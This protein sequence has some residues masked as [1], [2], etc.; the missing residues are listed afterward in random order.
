MV[1]AEALVVEVL[2]AVG[3]TKKRII[4]V[5]V[6]GPLIPSGMY[7]VHKGASADRKF[8]PICIAT[9]KYVL[10]IT[11]AKL[12]TNTSHNNHIRNCHR[13]IPGGV[14]SITC[15]LYDD[16]VRAGIPTTAFHKEWK[17]EY[18]NKTDA[19]N[20]D[21]RM[22]AIENWM[23]DNEPDGEW[24]A[25]DD[26]RFTLEPNLILIDFDVGLNPKHVDEVRARWPDVKRTLLV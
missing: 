6:D 24:I 9:L 13:D 25:F 4:F 8:S 11:G 15:N 10:E 18:P 3:M 22:V 1:E 17:T 7:L 5:D 2:V 16:L 26:Y 12:V 19:R 21:D 14:E 20:L 23:N